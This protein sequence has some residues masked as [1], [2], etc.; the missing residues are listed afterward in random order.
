MRMPKEE[1]YELSLQELR[2]AI[3]G[4]V[5]LKKQTELSDLHKV[6][7]T[8]YSTLASSGR[9]REGLRPEDLFPLE[10][11]K[12]KVVAERKY[13]TREEARAA[14]EFKRKRKNGR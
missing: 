3:D 12:K 10:G 8:I 6:R 7:L 9:M 14:L 13:K 5:E 1:L 4:H 2:W 11:D